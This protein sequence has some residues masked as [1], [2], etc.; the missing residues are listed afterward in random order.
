M[1]WQRVVIRG[2]FK[3]RLSIGA[4]LLW[5]IVVVSARR[6]L[7][8]PLYPG[9]PFELEFVTRLFKL[10][11][12]TLLRFAARGDVDKCRSAIDSVVF[13]L[14][15]LCAVNRQTE[16]NAPLPGTWFDS[17]RPGPTLLYFHGGGYAFYPAMS[18]S[19][20]AAVTL[21][22]GGRTFIPHY[23]LAPE[24]PFPAQRDDGLASY[25]WLLELGVKPSEIV[26]AGDSAGGHLVFSALLEVEKNGLPNP[27]AALAI[28]PWVDLTNHGESMEANRK[29]DWMTKEMADQ[30]SAWACARSE[31]DDTLFSVTDND[32]TGLPPTLVQYGGLEIF[33]D[34][35]D[36]FRVRNSKACNLTFETW[37]NMNHNFQ[38]FGDLLLESTDALTRIA[39]FVAALR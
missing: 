7:R 39:A 14:P 22:V 2:S 37:P 6:L 34:T 19:I 16:Y 4:G 27:L 17:S 13:P 12:R 21:A 29:F 10:Q 26:V 8:G 28:S 25:R 31:L 20:I 5:L 30:L 9:W 24:F 18:N 36:A 35:L 11:G 23:R 15:A 32:L 1:P 38:G 3:D 33:S